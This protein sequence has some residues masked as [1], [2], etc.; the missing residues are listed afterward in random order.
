MD[1]LSVFIPFFLNILPVGK[2]L[3]TRNFEMKHCM[4]CLKVF[5]KFVMTIDSNKVCLEF[6]ASILGKRN[7]S[8]SYS[9][10]CATVQ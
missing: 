10:S 5:K 1:K 7:L 4:T 6:C 2:T 9:E 3:K 8:L